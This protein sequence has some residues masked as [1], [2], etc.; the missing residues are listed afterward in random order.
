MGLKHFPQ[1]NVRS[2]LHEWIAQ[3]GNADPRPMLDSYFWSYL[4]NSRPYIGGYIGS[5]MIEIDD[6]CNSNLGE[7]NWHRLFNKIWFTSEQDLVL[8]KLTWSGD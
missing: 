4:D 2:F 1:R 5:R 3:N 6:W 8:Y 7:E